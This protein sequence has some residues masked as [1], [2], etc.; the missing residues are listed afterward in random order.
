VMEEGEG[1]ESQSSLGRGQPFGKEGWGTHEALQGEK[2][3]LLCI[4]GGDSHN[5]DYDE[6]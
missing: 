3:I 6:L 1:I 2:A 4:I 5:G